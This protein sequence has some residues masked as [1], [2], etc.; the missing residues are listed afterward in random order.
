MQISPD[1]EGQVIY[2]SDRRS[3]LPLQAEVDSLINIETFTL[4]DTLFVLRAISIQDLLQLGRLV[5]LERFHLYIH[6]SV[7]T[8]IHD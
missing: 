4:I 8:L 7:R 6:G 3:A 1:F 5:S 2:I